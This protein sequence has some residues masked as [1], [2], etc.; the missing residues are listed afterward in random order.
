MDLTRQLLSALHLLAEHRIVHSDIKPDNV[1]IEE[2]QE[3]AS[4]PSCRF[5]DLGSAFTFDCPESLSLA[6]PE[7]M[8]PEALETCAAGRPGSISSGGGVLSHL[9][10]GS[11][12]R[13]T[14]PNV[15]KATSAS[16]TSAELVLQMQRRSKP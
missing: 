3:R 5:I 8:P 1:L 7:Y 12:G 9:K 11:L 2:R 14:A 16:A 13:S 10:L 4:M 15:R 6:T